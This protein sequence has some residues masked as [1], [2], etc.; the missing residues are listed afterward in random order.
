MSKFL[1]ILSIILLVLGLSFLINNREMPGSR[2]EDRV[3]AFHNKGENS[4]CP[5]MLIKK[6]G[7]L[8]LYNSNEPKEEGKNP[9]HFNNLDEYINH[10]EKERSQGKKCPILYLQSETNTQGEEVYRIRPS[11]FD[12]QG[13]L[14]QSDNITTDLVKDSRGYILPLDATRDRKPYNKGNYA[15]FDPHNLHVGQ[16]TS[17]DN[18]HKSTINGKYSYNPMDSNWGGVEYT[19]SAVDSGKYEDREVKKPKL[20]TPKGTH[21]EEVPTM[22]KPPE[23]IL[24]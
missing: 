16:F 21:H 15:S 18:I 5:N 12:M 22:F 7:H 24:S 14:Q 4:E 19:K 6:D 8:L 3:D 2:P 17:L 10:L 23:D 9:K 20:F 11:P 13:G 1:K